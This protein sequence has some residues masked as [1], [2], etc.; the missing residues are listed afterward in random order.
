MSVAATAALLVGGTG[1]AMALNSST[2]GVTSWT[3]SNN[4]T[5]TVRDIASDGFSVRADYRR[6]GDTL[7]RVLVED[8]GNG[9]QRSTTSSIVVTHL[10]GCVTRPVI[11][12]QCGSWDPL[13][14]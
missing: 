6:T 3:T 4:Q 11:P 14:P 9:F 5:V 2:G 1:S 12:D 8:R 10:R 7:N 13:Q